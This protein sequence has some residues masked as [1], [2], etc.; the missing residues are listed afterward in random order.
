MN[1]YYDLKKDDRRGF[2]SKL[3]IL[4]AFMDECEREGSVCYPRLT[5][6]G[7]DVWNKYFTAEFDS[8]VYDTSIELNCRD[9]PTK[10]EGSDN[11]RKNIVFNDEIHER[12]EKIY[13]SIG[14]PDVVVYSRE[15]DKSADKKEVVIA[16][17]IYSDCIEKLNISS[18][19]LAISDC[20]YTIEILKQRFSNIVTLSTH[21]SENIMPLHRLTNNKHNF[22]KNINEEIL[23]DELIVEI[24]LMLRSKTILYGTWS[25]LLSMMHCFADDT[26]RPLL[27]DVKDKLEVSVLDIINYYKD[28]EIF[29]WKVIEDYYHN[30]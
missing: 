21:R 9:M 7:K 13:N 14:R 12:A 8:S 16:P 11:F 17:S 15:T 28:R 3:R 19:I 22:N 25:G 1:Y 30:R 10:K 24:L 4:N 27:I 5:I 6:N 18:P 2:C 20:K 29:L 23:L 26:S